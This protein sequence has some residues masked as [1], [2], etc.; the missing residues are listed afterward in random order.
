MSARQ[1]M[2]SQRYR[3]ESSV[4]LFPT[5][6]DTVA[7][8]VI[9]ASKSLDK[10]ESQQFLQTWQAQTMNCEPQED[11]AFCH[12]PT[13]ALSFYSSHSL[14]LEV[15]LNWF[16]QE[17]TFAVGNRDSVTCLFAVDTAADAAL[18]KLLKQTFLSVLT[19]EDR[20]PRRLP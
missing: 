10:A 7:H 17:A 6:P 19:E 15:E 11:F 4:P 9:V 8:H 20:R 13:F 12:A 16:C 18:R 1:H 14:V 5:D 2:L 3:A